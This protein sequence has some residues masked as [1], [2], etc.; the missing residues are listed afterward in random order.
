M[1]EK[2]KRSRE[3]MNAM[4]IEMVMK[5]R[6]DKKQERSTTK[7]RTKSGKKYK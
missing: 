6:G 1:S 3:S 2:A 4:Q 7:Q 5:R